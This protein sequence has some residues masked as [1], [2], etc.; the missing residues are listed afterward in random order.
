MQKCKFCGSSVIAP[1]G[2]VRSSSFFGRVGALDFGDLSSLTGKALKIAEIQGLI[3]NGR[4]IEAIKVFRETFGVGLAEAKNAV[5]ALER[6]ESVD[7]SGMSVSTGKA[8]IRVAVDGNTVKKVALGVGGSIAGVFLVTAIIII[9]AIVFA[10]YMVSRTVD[11]ALDS[12]P[13]S[14]APATPVREIKPGGKEDSPSIAAE[15]L[16][17]GGEGIGA[18]KFKDNRTVAVAPDGR[19]FSAD[20]SA[21]R[22][23]AFD[24][25]GQFQL[26]VAADTNKTVDALAVDR[27]GNLFVLQ[28]Y[29]INRFDSA[30]GGTLG[31]TR[32]DNASDMTLALDGKLYVSTRRGEIHVLGADGEKIRALKIAKDLNLDYI[33][34]IAVDGT[35]NLF[36]VDGRNYAI[37]KLSPDGKLLTRF[38]GRPE[39]P[40]NRS[41]KGMFGGR[42]NDVAIDSQGRLYVCEI[43]RVSIFDSN[44]NYLNDFKTKQAFGIAIDD[45][46]QVFIA[47]RPNVTAY[48]VAL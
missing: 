45:K 37:F 44:G 4:K 47:S 15:I 1:T 17:F 38:G 43:E 42:P 24:A 25:N 19:I 7:L 46:D 32:V 31:T 12:V 11:R 48:K 29:N 33:E 21:G 36:V 26:Q 22:I 8:P 9:G 20:Y 13:N 6:G 10:F 2:V 23:Q 30:N 16:R 14:S 5:E 28:G 35:G 3:Q 18:G 41:A 39:S 40:A 34:H 27:K